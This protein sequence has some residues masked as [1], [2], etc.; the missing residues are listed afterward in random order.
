MG[1]SGYLPKTL[2]PDQMAE[3]LKTIAAGGTYF[4][5]NK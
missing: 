3:A 5:P 1:V 2:S 4:P